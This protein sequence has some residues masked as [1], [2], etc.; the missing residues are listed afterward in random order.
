MP[1]VENIYPLKKE[2]IKPSNVKANPMYL[3]LP[4]IPDMD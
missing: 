1:T 2:Q 3:N 4:D